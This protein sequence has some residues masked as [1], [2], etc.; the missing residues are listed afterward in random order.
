M[1]FLIVT[2][3]V[4]CIKYHNSYRYAAQLN[5]K[6]IVELCDPEV[7]C[8]CCVNGELLLLLLLS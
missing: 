7:G 3:I 2:C 6:A 4:S 5:T 1:P 8:F